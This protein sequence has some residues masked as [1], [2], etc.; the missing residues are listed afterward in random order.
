MVIEQPAEI[1]LHQKS[2]EL[3]IAFEDGARYRL[4]YEFLRVHSPSAEV[5]GHGPG[6]EI[7][8]SGKMHVGVKAVTPVGSY[9]LKIEFD[10]GH[11]SGLYTWEYLY[12][13]G[14]HQ[15]ALWKE[16]LHRLEEAGESREANPQSG[17]K[18]E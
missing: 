3:E 4:P 5:R 15:D 18:H 9:A 14:R 7:L 1:I 6:Q 2:K 13:L 12:N 17:I 8:Q 16:Y 10:D 11:D